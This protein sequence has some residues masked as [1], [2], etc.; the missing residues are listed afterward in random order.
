MPPPPPTP[1]PHHTTHTHTH[2]PTHSTHT[3]T[4]V[5]KAA[6]LLA[7][8][9]L[10]AVHLHAGH[11]EKARRGT[12][13]RG[14]VSGAGARQTG[15]G[16]GE[17]AKSAVGGC[18]AALPAAAAQMSE[19]AWLPPRRMPDPCH[20]CACGLRATR[21]PAVKLAD[22]VPPIVPLGIHQL[23][24]AARNLRGCWAGGGGAGGERIVDARDGWGGVGGAR[25]SGCSAAAVEGA[26][27][28][29]LPAAEQ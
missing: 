9:L 15:E 28:R 19:P 10:S 1:T 13:Q 4:D 27:L 7:E 2:A 20:A 23:R 25:C 29:L 26:P 17:G 18:W 8:A 16:A 11:A 6:A 14:S 24:A 22:A 12:E 5:L 3:R 21:A